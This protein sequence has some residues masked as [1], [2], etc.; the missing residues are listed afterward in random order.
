MFDISV[1]IP[2]YNDCPWLGS[3]LDSIESQ[4]LPD[5]ILVE[6]ILI[7]DRPAPTTLSYL[8]TRNRKNL[9]VMISPA[10]G[11]VAAL[12]KGISVAK[13]KY[14]ARIDAD[15]EMKPD[16]LR[17]QFNF[18]ENNAGVVVLGSQVDIVNVDGLFL[19]RSNYFTRSTDIHK[20]LKFEC[21]ISHPSVMF[22][23]D[24]FI[25]LGGYRDFYSYA[26]D[27]DL[28]IRMMK[29]GDIA[30]LENSLTRYRIHESQTSLRKA[31]QQQVATEAV[32]ISNR[33]ISKGKS[34]LSEIYP[35]LE[36][37]SQSNRGRFYSTRVKISQ[38]YASLRRKDSVAAFF[39]LPIIAITSPVRFYSRALRS[40]EKWRCIDNN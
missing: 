38:K 39:L 9:I 26:E 37:W 34:D 13:G 6:T 14:I 30:I 16:R 31:Y 25:S 17:T 32:R 23:K 2:A 33:R 15:D 40:F 11:I 3:T 20:T 27:Y 19:S 8:E 1:V 12:N 4:V 24:E 21:H 5:S 29:I 28:W 36:N 35:S 22:R 7:L 10:E 18:L